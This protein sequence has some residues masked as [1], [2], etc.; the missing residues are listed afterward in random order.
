MLDPHKKYPGGV[1]EMASPGFGPLP[2]RQGSI[3]GADEF[4]SPVPDTAVFL[5]EHH[6]RVPFLKATPRARLVPSAHGK[7]DGTSR[8]CGVADLRNL[9]RFAARDLN[10]GRPCG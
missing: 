7:C 9:R 10:G 5:D 2:R 3:V 8:T 4:N 1:S 6:L